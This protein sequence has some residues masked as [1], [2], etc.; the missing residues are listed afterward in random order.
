MNSKTLLGQSSPRIKTT[1]YTSYPSRGHEVSEFA[2]AVKMP[3]MPWQEYAINEACRIKDD[4]WASKTIG[5][6]VARQNGKTHLLRM[7]I[8]AGLFLWDERLQVA[9]A[10]NRD[11]GLE[12]FRAVV[13][14]IDGFKWLRSEVKSVTRANGREE[15]LLKNGCRYKVLAPTPGSARG[16]SVDTVYLDEVRQH[17]TTDAFAALAYTLNARPNPQ[18][19]ALSNAG[20]SN[21][22]VLNRLRQ[23]ALDVIE[24]NT[25][26]DITWLEWSAEPNKKLSDRNGWTQAN[27]ALG[28]TINEDVLAARMNDTPALIQTEM[29]CQW[30]DTLDSPWPHGFWNGCTIPN[31]ELKP[32]KP[33]F[34][35]LEISPDRTSWSLCGSQVLD[36]GSIGVGIMEYD[37]QDQPIDDLKIADRIAH[38]ARKYEPRVIMGNKFSSDSVISRLN[39]AGIRAE[40][41][42]GGKYYQAC[43]ETLGAITGNR[44]SHSNQEVLSKSMNACV[45][46]TNESGAWYVARHKAAVPAISMILS[47][48]KAIELGY[49]ADV[50]IAI[51]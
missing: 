10:Q 30:V 17:K 38:W 48:H 44:L 3:L 39:Q 32:D 14:I 41:I 9:T 20:D 50:D 42:N 1:T 2:K 23:R 12:T 11:I 21:S 8:L 13:D 40:T 26:D 29:L 51:L 36:D 4:K 6:L 22:V 33:T 35:G 24:N 46:R 15:I 45:K 5:V 16:L 28:Y 37:L 34:M 27:P 49:S 47:I 19:W 18:M 7:R 31:L 43:D 25:D